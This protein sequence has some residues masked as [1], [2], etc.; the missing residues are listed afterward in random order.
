MRRLYVSQ[1][2]WSLRGRFTVDDEHG[3]PLYEVEGS[4]FQIPKHFTVRDVAGRERARVWK[5]PL[6]WL[7]RF[8]VEVDGVE[9][10]SIRKEFTFLRSQYTIDGPALTVQGSFWDMTFE[11]QQ[12]GAVIGRVD[13]RWSLRDRYAIEIDRPED[14]LVVLGIVLAIDYVKKQ[15]QAG[16]SAGA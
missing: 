7:P 9:V 13:K 14:E 6:S 3:G 10:A 8:H 15:E 16:A 5:E 12:R 1:R 4:L 11:V 2:M